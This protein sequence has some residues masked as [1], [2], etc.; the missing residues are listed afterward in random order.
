MINLSDNDFVPLEHFNLKW[1]WSDPKWNQLPDFALSEI[2]PLTEEKSKEL[3]QHS[4]TLCNLSGLNSDV[5]TEA[6][7]IDTS[8]QA[9]DIRVWLEEL[10][11]RD[12]KEVFISWDKQKGVVTKWKV[13]CEY[14][15]DFCYAGSD[16]VTIWPAT[17]EWVLSYYHTEEF[18]YGRRH[19]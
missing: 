16:D 11:P 9:Q 5:F 7:K 6:A 18:C 17:E 13:F 12:T 14:W 3:W 4:L 2:R 8:Q 10:I 19:V 1:R 15:D